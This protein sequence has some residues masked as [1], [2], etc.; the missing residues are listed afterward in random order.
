LQYLKD[1]KAVIEIK[2]P[3]VTTYRYD[4]IPNGYSIEDLVTVALD[5]DDEYARD[6]LSRAVTWSNKQSNKK[7]I[8]ELGD[9]IYD[10]TVHISNHN[11]LE[12]PPTPIKDTS[13]RYYKRRSYVKGPRFNLSELSADIINERDKKKEFTVA[14]RLQAVLQNYVNASITG[15]VDDKDFIN[16]ITEVN[17]VQFPIFEQPIVQLKEYLNR[18]NAKENDLLLKHE[19]LKLA[20]VYNQVLGRHDIQNSIIPYYRDFAL[21][22]SDDLVDKSIRLHFD[23]LPEKFL[24]KAPSFSSEEMIYFRYEILDKLIGKPQDVSEWPAQFQALLMFCNYELEGVHALF[25]EHILDELH[26]IRYTILTKNSH[27]NSRVQVSDLT[28]KDLLETISNYDISEPLE[29]VFNLRHNH[30][31]SANLYKYPEKYAVT[32]NYSN[33]EVRKRLNDMIEDYIRQN[34]YEGLRVS[35]KLLPVNREGTIL[36]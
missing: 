34:L 31:L 8:R 11:N 15:Y 32:Y 25:N 17:F 29:D 24:K 20:R 23:D 21:P 26:R 22:G 2:N 27:N 7:R 33:F 9:T 13:Y 3:D 12:E 16:R 4:N 10:I 19:L 36:Q 6:W 18:K 28:I 14:P 30:I 5:L 35:E 1:N